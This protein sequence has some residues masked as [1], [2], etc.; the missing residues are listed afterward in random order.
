MKTYYDLTKKERKE[1]EKEFK[2]TPV[3][4][5]LNSNKVLFEV[6]LGVFFFV[7][8]FVIGFTSGVEEF[9]DQSSLMLT[10]LLEVLFYIMLLI[11]SAYNFY[12]N[13]NFTAWL[14]NKYDIKR[15]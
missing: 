5:D 12:V 2:K 4:K 11:S 6:I 15:W 7:Y 14:K 9:L 8:G 13:I 10:N 1:Y 3:G